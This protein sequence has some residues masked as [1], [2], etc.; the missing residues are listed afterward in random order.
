MTPEE[1]KEA[2]KYQSPIEVIQGEITAKI[3]GEIMTAIQQ[4]D[5]RVDKEELIKALQY[6]RKQYEK[7]YQD[8][9]EDYQKPEDEWVPIKFRPLTEEEKERYP[10]EADGIY[11]CRLPDD[12]EE[13]LITTRWGAVC[14][15]TFQ[16]DGDTCYFEDHDDADEVTAWKHLPKPYEPEEK[17]CAE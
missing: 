6:D 1:F 7:G 14:I 15:D 16:N 8:A 4:Y 13:V 11:D 3:E 9:K 12:G 5:I 17:G 2:M 10:E